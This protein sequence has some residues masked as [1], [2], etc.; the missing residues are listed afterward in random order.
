MTQLAAGLLGTSLLVASC[1]ISPSATPKPSPV[2]S[3]TAALPS[4]PV[5]VD[6]EFPLEATIPELQDAMA[7]G[8]LSSVELVDF[9]L[10]RIA[11]YDDAGPKLNAFILVNPSAREAAAALDAERAASGPRGPMH[12]I[13][14]VLKDNIGTADMPTTAGSLALADLIPTEDAFQVRMLDR[15]STRL[16][17]SHIQKSRMPSS[18]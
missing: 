15:K 14:V 2:S 17:S 10:A 8:R 6:L 16:N 13:P 7:A 1:A 9:Y 11:A 12:G 18:A 5:V 4:Q 3:P